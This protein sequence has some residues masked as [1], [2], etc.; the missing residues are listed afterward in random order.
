MTPDRLDADDVTEVAEFAALES[1]VRCWIRETAVARPEGEVLRL[2][3]ASS[4]IALEA[5]IRR[6]SATG[7]HRFDEVSIAGHGP[8]DLPT[9][10]ALIAREAAGGQSSADLV[11]RVLD[12]A[13]RSAEFVAY[14]R[15]EPDDPP[16]TTPFLAGEQALILGHPLHP[17]PKSRDGLREPEARAY[18][19]ELRG[20]FP[21][22]WFAAAPAIVS[23][24]SALSR[25]AIDIVSTLDD[26]AAPAGMVA[27]PAHPWQAADLLTRPA[28]AEAIR[29]G[30]LVDLGPAGRPWFP[31]SSL[32][33]VYRPD[34]PVMLKLSLGLRITNSRRENLRKELVRGVEVTRLLDAGI[35]AW[36]AATRPWFD[37]VRD[38][39]WLATDVPGLDVVLRTNS[40]GIN[41][42]FRCVAGL[43]AA[44][45]GLG[46]SRLGQLVA[47]LAEKTG[48]SVPDAAQEWFG[49]YLTSVVEP[50]LWLAATYGI[51]LEAHH[52]NTLVGLDAA[53]WPIAGRYRDNQGYYF[54]ASRI[55]QLEKL[56]SG[57]GQE[58]DTIVPDEVA[59]ERL[60]YYLGINNV[61]GLIGGFGAAGLVEEDVLLD[62]L[63]R[64]FSAL[65]GEMEDEGVRVPTMID[66]F[67][68]AP[69]LRCKANL[70]T[71][72]HGMDELVGPVATQSVYVTIPNPLAS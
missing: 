3:L 19:P 25:T 29:D 15:S 32:R 31:T 14:R 57:A 55:G 53:G 33:T 27:I 10:A 46:S 7:W 26:V 48:Q 16:G 40:F 56:V 6:W 42:D 47:G 20:S 62:V 18:A 52:Q 1:L 44:R 45:P 71:R 30:L 5:R 21:L 64:R 72:A 24:D 38:P 65:R 17:T 59:D 49:R 39:A 69:S 12:S 22:H 11:S 2:P 66:T 54:S 41:D 34:A 13:R 58:S 67:L 60:G 51:A 35:A 8:V 9:A 50:V 23:S 37:I 28:A 4:G 61:F 43:V 63:R 68:E 36:F 70:L